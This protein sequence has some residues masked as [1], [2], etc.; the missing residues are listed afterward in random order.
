[1]LLNKIKPCIY[2]KADRNKGK[3]D[4]YNKKIKNK[5]L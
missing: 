2:N 1:M 4:D 5:S 3:R